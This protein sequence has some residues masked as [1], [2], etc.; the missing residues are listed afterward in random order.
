M[1]ITITTTITISMVT[2][3]PIRPTEREVCEEEFVKTCRIV[4]RARAY[5]HTTRVCRRPLVEECQQP[6]YG[7]YQAPGSK[8]PEL[9]CETFYETECKE[10][11]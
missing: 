3:I 11:S 4:M 9:V 5:N 2:M 7:G 1:G 6:S 8:Q 10:V